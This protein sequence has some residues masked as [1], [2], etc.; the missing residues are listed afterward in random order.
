MP[1]RE[2]NAEMQN[3]CRNAKL[4]PKVETNAES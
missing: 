1:K 4:M 2:I 3:Q